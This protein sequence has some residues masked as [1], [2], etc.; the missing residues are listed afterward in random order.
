MIVRPSYALVLAASLGALLGCKS[1]PLHA[2]GATDGSTND[3]SRCAGDRT[4]CLKGGPLGH[5]VACGDF[6]SFGSCV[7]DQ[8]TCPEGMVDERACT[9][10]GPGVGCAGASCTPDGWICPDAGAD[11]RPDA[12]DADGSSCAGKAPIDCARTFGA[13]T[14]P[15]TI[16]IC[17]DVAIPPTCVDGHW[18]CVGGIDFHLCTCTS[19]IPPGCGCTTHGLSCSDGGPDGP[20]DAGRDASCDVGCAPSNAGSFCGANEQQW[21]CHGGYDPQAFAACR[22]PGT[23]LPRY[24]CPTTFQPTCH[25]G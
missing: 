9:C 11:G 1:S 18:A 20:N 21:E 23:N 3:G 19:P 7:G 2:D 12:T 10:G 15:G 16:I 17:D 5:G 14:T 25:A 8:W 24:C 6:G 22:D 13:N 4:T